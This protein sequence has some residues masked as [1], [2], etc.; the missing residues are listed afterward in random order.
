MRQLRLQ[1]ANVGAPITVLIHVTGSHS[2]VRLLIDHLTELPTSSMAD[3]EEDDEGRED[4]N[5]WGS[6]GQDYE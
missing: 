6:A 2:D 3:D 4:N 5:A 1:I